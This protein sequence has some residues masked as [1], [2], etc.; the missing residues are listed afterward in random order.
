MLGWVRKDAQQGTCGKECKIQTENTSP[1]ENQTFRGKGQE[2]LR[3][4]KL[5]KKYTG[6]GARIV[7]R[8][9]AAREYG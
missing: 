2:R 5:L 8:N 7:L 9:I 4:I 1:V 6:G 3:R